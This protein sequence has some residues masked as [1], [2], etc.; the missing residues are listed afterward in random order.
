MLPIGGCELDLFKF[1]NETDPTDLDQ[2]E[3]VNGMRSVTWTERYRTPGDFIISGPLSSS[4]REQLPLGTLISHMATYEIMFVEN[5]EIKE[6]DGEPQIFITGRSLESWLENRVAG[7]NQ[8]WAS[9]PATIPNYTLAAN[10]T[11]NQAN[12]LIGDHIYPAYT[13]NASDDLAYIVPTTTVT[14]TS[15]E[16]IERV[17]K[18][19]NVHQRLIELLEV[20]DLGIK[21]VRRSQFGAHAGSAYSLFV[22]HSGSDKSSSVIFSTDTKDLKS[23]GYLWSLKNLKNAA[24]ITGRYV[25]TVVLPSDTGL[26]KRWMFVDASDIDDSLT[27]VPTGGTLT[28]IRTQ[29]Q[30]RGR[31]ALKAQKVINLTNV[32][33]SPA[34]VYR[35]RR[36]YN[37]GDIVSVDGNYGDIE[38]RRV[39]EYVEIEDENGE[40]SHPTLATLDE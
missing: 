4:L 39:I 10:Y 1:T 6:D 27:A 29:M 35:Y 11:H 12:R 18:R 23:V 34:S 15:G 31:E 7:S 5:H 37:I 17:I 40:S 25:E 8:N 13:V 14:D 3:P 32:E 24:L 16:S 22:I 9:P 30:T 33:V 28:S 21:T 20:D 19:G 2:G 38:K 36:D 26:D